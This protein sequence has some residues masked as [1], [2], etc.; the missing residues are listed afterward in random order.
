MSQEVVMG[1][2]EVTDLKILL[3]GVYIDGCVHVYVIIHRTYIY[4]QRHSF[5]LSTFS[6]A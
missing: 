5:L 6:Y 4:T 2:E 1:S 3:K